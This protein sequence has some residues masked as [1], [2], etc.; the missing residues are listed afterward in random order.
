MSTPREDRTVGVGDGAAAESGDFVFV[1]YALGSCVGIT[2]WDPEA[3][4]GGMLHAQLPVSYQ[5]EER[6]QRFPFLYTDT[7]VAELLRRLY[8][9]GADNRRL[10]VVLAGCAERTDSSTF[11]VGQRNLAVARRVLWKNDIV[12]K[13]EDV[14][15]DTPR[16]LFLDMESGE[17]TVRMNGT[18]KRL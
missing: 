11:R 10:V 1:T 15:G 3:R 2:A 9:L 18:L 17:T 13:A 6:A 7:A 5:H 16:S 4:V 8:R 14:G 12:V